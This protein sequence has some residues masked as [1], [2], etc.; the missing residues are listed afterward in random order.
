MDLEKK[1]FWSAV[2]GHA[3][4]TVLKKSLHLSQDDETLGI[5]FA[6][7]FRTLHNFTSESRSLLIDKIFCK[8]ATLENLLAC[9]STTSDEQ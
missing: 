9:F 4:W 3:V 2:R 8:S 6:V 1:Y 5:V 7:T